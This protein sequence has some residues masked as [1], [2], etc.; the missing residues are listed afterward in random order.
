M[1]L[2]IKTEVLKAMTEKAQKCASCNPLIPLTNIMA[3]HVEGG[4]V[5]F[6]TTDATNYMKVCAPILHEEP[7]NASVYIAL[8]SKLVQKLTSESVVIDAKDGILIVTADGEYKMEMPL[9][10]NGEPVDFNVPSELTTSNA[11][12]EVIEKKI[13][14]AVIDTVKPALATDFDFGSYVNYFVT[15][16]TVVG[17]DTAQASMY[18]DKLLPISNILL[19]AKLLDLVN[20]LPSAEINFGQDGDIYVFEQ[21]HIDAVPYIMT[22]YGRKLDGVSDYDYSVITSLFDVDLQNSCK[23]AK[24]AL[25]SCL[26]RITLFVGKY[27]NNQIKLNFTNKDLTICSVTNSGVER[28]VYKEAQNKSA[29]FTC[30]VNADLFKNQIKAQLTDLIEIQFG[31]D[32][33]IKFVDGVH[34]SV[35]ALEDE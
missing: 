7:F 4:E 35:L 10:E 16:A 9:D 3:I 25:L 21:A 34:S 2:T 23:I 26:D 14:S 24:S 29:N 5:K 27:D 22:V 32:A 18:N 12:T 1:S 31:S 8:F 13:I 28:I 17:S 15:D 33:L 11:Q 30:T 19:D 6:I 20:T